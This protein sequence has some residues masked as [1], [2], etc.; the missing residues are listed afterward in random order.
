MSDVNIQ[1]LQTKLIT[2]LKELNNAALLCS[3]YD[4]N[5]NIVDFICPK[6]DYNTNEPPNSININFVSNHSKK[7][8][9]T[10]NFDNTFILTLGLNGNEYEFGDGENA[11]DTNGNLLFYYHLDSVIFRI[12][13]RA[14]D[15]R[16]RGKYTIFDINNNTIIVENDLC[17]S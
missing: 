10:Y 9:F 5:G 4:I 1:I 3:A 12:G 16:I 13:L 17:S 15:G 2:A 11:I 8:K 14:L 7:I 6:C